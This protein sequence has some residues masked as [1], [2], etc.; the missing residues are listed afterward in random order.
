MSRVEELEGR[1]WAIQTAQQ[2]AGVASTKGGVPEIVSVLRRGLL[3]DK[4]EGYKAGIRKFI[5]EIES[6]AGGMQRKQA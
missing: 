1:R 2:I 3:G 5:S 6:A 4:P